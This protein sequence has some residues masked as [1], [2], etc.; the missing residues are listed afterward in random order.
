MFYTIE[1]PLML[2]MMRT[3][4]LLALALV[5]WAAAQPG[6]NTT[7]I[8]FNDY[9]KPEVTN[10]ADYKNFWNGFWR[11][12]LNAS[13][14]Y[15]ENRKLTYALNIPVKK[16][17]EGRL[18]YSND[19]FALGARVNYPSLNAN[20][21]ATLSPV[22]E[23]EAYPT[24]AQGEYTNTYEG[25]GVLHNVGLIKT[26]TTF[27]KGKN[28]PH[29]LYLNVSDENDIVHPYFMG[30]LTFDGW[31][32]KT[33]ANPVYLTEVRDRA[34]VR[35]PNYPKVEPIVKFKSFV[36]FRNAEYVAGDF[37]AYF[38]YVRLVYDRAI[39]D[40]DDDINDEDMW[41]IR[42]SYSRNKADAENER[43]KSAGELERIERVKMFLPP[44][45]YE[46][47]PR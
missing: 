21:Y 29:S 47:K 8:D 13:G 20:A 44:A 33:W 4:L 11:V 40:Q 17:K 39:F 6:T 42:R 34:L 18:G 28:F 36:L 27:V 2:R 32:E 41:K 46:A 31:Q 14:D 7:L 22:Y 12:R 30:Y 1:E 25:K 26:I 19:G 38:G 45:S 23:F 5:G 43:L 37:V 15:I 35:T 3:V 9:G 24:N 10:N 16:A